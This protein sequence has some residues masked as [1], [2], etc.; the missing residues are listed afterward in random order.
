MT[1]LTTGHEP[2]EVRVVL[3][4]DEA[5]TLLGISRSHLLKEIKRG[6]IPH[7]RMG[8]RLVFSRERLLE[9]LSSDET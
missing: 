4:L 6:H 9:W 3:Y 8:R 1:A 5:A 2:H 7:K